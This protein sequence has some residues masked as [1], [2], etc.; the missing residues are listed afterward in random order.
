MNTADRSIALMDT[1][2]RRRFEFIEVLPDTTIFKKI[3]DDKI[4][5]VNDIDIKNMLD[6]INKR[7]EIL[8]DRE[9]TI[10]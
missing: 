8:Y 2:L 6:F 5:K 3:N 4:L 9:H 7:I 10:G 1:V